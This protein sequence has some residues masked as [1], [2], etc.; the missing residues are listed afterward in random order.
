MQQYMLRATWLKSSFAEKDLGVLVDTK[1]NISQQCA[2]AQ[3]K[4]TGILGCIRSV[5]SRL[6]KRNLLLYSAPVRPNLEYCVQFWAPQY[7]T[8]MDI[9]GR[10]QQRATKRIKS[11]SHTR[12]S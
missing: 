2:L 6:R 7:K 4:A 12:K 10:V 11:I 1:L 3:K 8:E 5:A 9:M